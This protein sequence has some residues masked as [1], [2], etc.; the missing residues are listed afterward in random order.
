M[1]YCKVA[2]P[3]ERPSLS[4]AAAGLTGPGR[5]IPQGPIRE[6]AASCGYL[7]GLDSTTSEPRSEEAPTNQAHV[8]MSSSVPHEQAVSTVFLPRQDGAQGAWTKGAREAPVIS[9]ELVQARP[10]EWGGSF[11]AG[12]ALAA[13]LNDQ[14]LGLRRR[15]LE[16]Q[17]AT[18]YHTHHAQEL[19]PCGVSGT[20]LLLQAW[21]TAG[22]GHVYHGVF[23]FCVFSFCKPRPRRGRRDPAA[24]KSMSLPIWQLPR[25]A[26]LSSLPPTSRH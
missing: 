23:A 9:A 3:I 4:I 16:L 8:C 18:H 10:A 7:Q 25:P 11:L 24:E 19:R 2:G 17:Q 22:K 1:A 26:P 14:P 12:P 6:E 20:R 21:K 5:A 13:S 15:D